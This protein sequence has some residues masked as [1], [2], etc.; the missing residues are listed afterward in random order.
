MRILAVSDVDDANASLRA[1]GYTDNVGDPAANKKLSADR[2]A[3][4]A[5]PALL[6][7]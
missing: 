6:V 3:A 4:V 7:H 2:A 1:K 5:K